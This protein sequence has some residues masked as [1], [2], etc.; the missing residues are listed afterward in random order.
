MLKSACGIYNK[1]AKKVAKNRECNQ[2]G[3]FFKYI[4]CSVNDTFYYKFDDIC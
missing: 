4:N 2:V 3:Y 1:G